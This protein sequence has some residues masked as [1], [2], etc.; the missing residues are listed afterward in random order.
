[1]SFI[2]IDYIFVAVIILFAII[3]VVKGFVDNIFGKLSWILGIL[4]AFFFYERV[5]TGFFGGIGNKIVANILAFLILFVVIFLIV[6]L[7]Q[8]VMGKIF[9]GAILGSLDRALG[10][11]F[12]IVE[13]IAVVALVIFILGNQ[14]FFPV[15]NLF[16]GSFFYSLFEKYMSNI[17][18]QSLEGIVNNV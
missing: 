9:S 7:L 14:P 13:G 1:M 10:F 11:F 6:K 4:G 8:V 12:G 3:G 15:D 18:F 2:V 5:A 16:N 17:N